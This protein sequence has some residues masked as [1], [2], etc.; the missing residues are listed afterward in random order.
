MLE[1]AH[2]RLTGVWIECLPWRK[3]IG[4]WDRPGTLFY[5]DPPYWGSEHY[6]GRGLFEREEFEALSGALKGLRGRFVLTLNDVPEV[7]QL[8]RWAKVKAVPVT[9]TLQGKGGRQAAKELIIVP[10]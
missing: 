6:Y 1:A 9:Y 4:R 3:F 7:R 5:L 10:R 8:F 2:E